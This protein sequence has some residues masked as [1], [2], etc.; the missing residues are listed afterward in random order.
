[1]CR[2]FR[3]KKTVFNYTTEAW[4][5]RSF[6]LPNFNGDFVLLTPI[7]ILTRDIIWINREDLVSSF[8]NLPSSI[9]DGQL[10]AQ[11]NN[12]FLKILPQHPTGKDRTEAAKKTI[13]E[14]PILIDYY[15][16]RKEDNGE[17]AQEISKKKVSYSKNL[18][19]EQ[20]RDLSILLNERT[21]FY[22]TK[23]DTYTACKERALY[24]KQVVEN[25]DGYRNFY[26]KF[27][28]P[29][30]KEDDLLILYRLTWF[31][32]IYSVDTQVNNG[33][34]P[35]DV[36]VSL[37]SIDSTIVEFKLARN[38]QLKKNLQNQVEIYKKANN[39]KKSLK[40]IFYF[41]LK[42]LRTVEKILKELNLETAENIILIDTRKDNKISASKAGFTPLTTK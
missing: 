20:F 7:D 41:N 39:T 32:T 24:L 12:Y 40:I 28:Q 16:R 21:N 31:A 23:P 8:S 13:L 10:R 9:G 33:R 1:M 19:T 26:D 11:I 6:Y 14:Y 38:S 22:H 2:T 30:H 35:A 4:E 36:K 5:E 18:Y 29:V 25:N 17:Q 15:I 27:G 34:G 3:V 37:G 42:E